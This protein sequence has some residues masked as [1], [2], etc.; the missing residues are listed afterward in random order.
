[1][2]ELNMSRRTCFTVDAALDLLLR[3]DEA[4]FYGDDE[5]ASDGAGSESED[6][7]DSSDDKREHFLAA[8]IDTASAAM[9]FMSLD[10]S[11]AAPQATSSSS[12]P[13]EA[14]QTGEAAEHNRNYSCGCSLN[15]FRKFDEADV[16]V[17]VLHMKELERPESDLI[18]L[19]LLESG[20]HETALS[21]KPGEKRQRQRFRY[22]F[23]GVEICV[24]AFRTLYDISEKRLKNLRK[25]LHEH[26]VTAR[27]HGN[28]G[29]RPPNALEF[30]DVKNCLD[31]IKRHADVY[32][33]PHPAPL[34]GRDD[35]PPVFLPA[36]QTYKEVHA[37]FVALCKSEG[38]RAIAESTFHSIWHQCLPHI[39]FMTPRMD[40]CAVCEDLPRKVVSAAGEADKLTA[41]RN[42]E[43]HI[44]EAQKERELYKQR[45]V[46]AKTEYDD[47]VAA[48]SVEVSPLTKQ[49]YTFDFAQNVSLPHTARQIGP[50]YFKTPEKYNCSGSAVNLFQ[51][52]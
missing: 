7:S 45:A 28:R 32:G 41:C 35:V 22:S 27:V 11:H 13:S 16:E 20:R 1:M 5:C 17:N 30:A 46:D 50:I 24:A 18:I 48:G 12:S 34:R 26:G 51:S 19:G 15:C 9:D 29:R 47:Y 49:K 25:H 38:W 44:T 52:R 14:M 42:L 31:F 2:L 33:I 43:E 3:E 10:S 21:H 23:Q 8:T 40:V 6:S 4:E 37:E 36:H 39:R